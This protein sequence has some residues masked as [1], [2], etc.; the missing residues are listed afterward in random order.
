MPKGLVV[1]T[2]EEIKDQ[3]KLNAYLAVA[4]ATAHKY[5]GQFVARGHPAALRENGKDQR[6][7]VAM[8]PSLEVAL[9]WYDGPEYK[10]ALDT[11]SDGAVR[12]FRFFETMD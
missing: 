11:L 5:G 12:N 2:Y 8:F 3:D 9:N 10:V 7:T 6:T 4:P 1:V